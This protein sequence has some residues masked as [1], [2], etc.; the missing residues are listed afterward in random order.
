MVFADP[1]GVLAH[2]QLGRALSRSGE[3]R[4]ATSAYRTFLAI[5]KNADPDIP[6]FQQASAEYAQLQ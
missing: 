5:W 3:T 6:I 1:I 4:A 2:L